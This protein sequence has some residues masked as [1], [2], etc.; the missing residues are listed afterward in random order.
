VWEV[1]GGDK[2]IWIARQLGDDVF[3]DPIREINILGS[4]AHVVEGKECNRG[5][6]WER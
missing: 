6:V 1:A 4:I 2:Q 5:L 3:R